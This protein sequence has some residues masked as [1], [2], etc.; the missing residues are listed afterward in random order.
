[1][2]IVG[3]AVLQCVSRNRIGRAKIYV[4][5]GVLP[6]ELVRNLVEFTPNFRVISTA[7]GFKN[8]GYLPWSLAEIDDVSDV[9]VAE[10]IMNRA[11][12]RDLAL[13]R[14]KPAALDQL[15]AVAAEFESIGFHTAQ[16]HIHFA[17]AI[18]VRKHHHDNPFA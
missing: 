14:L 6:I 17:G 1:M 8:A 2:L 15:H 5:N 4:S 11:T 7:S 12:E 18:F 16:R 13:A 3:N 9:G 10:S